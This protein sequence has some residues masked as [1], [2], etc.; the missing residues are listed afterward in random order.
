MLNIRRKEKIMNIKAIKDGLTITGN[1]IGIL[2]SVTDTLPSG[3]KREEA[4]RLLV[5]AEQ[6]IK[7]A[8]ARL[9]P[10]LGFHLC[11]RC[12]PPEIMTLNNEGEFICRHCGLPMPDGALIEIP[13]EN[14]GSSGLETW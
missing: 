1:A 10:E 2:K 11:K 7:E 3:E 4:E 14:S 9:A 13:P 6:K 12:W 8:E 5:S